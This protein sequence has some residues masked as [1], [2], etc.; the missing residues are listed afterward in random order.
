VE[1]VLEEIKH[2]K[3]MKQGRGENVRERD[4]DEGG[5]GDEE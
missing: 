2:A 3:A 4:G 1:E 5:D